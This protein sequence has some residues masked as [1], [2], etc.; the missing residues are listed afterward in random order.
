M[1]LLATFQSLVLHDLNV[2]PVHHCSC[3]SMQYVVNQLPLSSC[4]NVLYS[5]LLFS[6]LSPLTSPSFLLFAFFPFVHYSPLLLCH[7]RRY[8][9]LQLFTF[10]RSFSRSFSAFPPSFP[11]LQPLS[12]PQAQALSC[13]E[14]LCCY[15]HG[16]SG[17]SR[18][19]SLLEQITGQCQA[20]ANHCHTSSHSNRWGG[21]QQQETM[22]MNPD[23]PSPPLGFKNVACSPDCIS[24]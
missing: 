7:F 19:A 23:E 10:T 4:Q 20:S 13:V 3:D 21:R 2:F 15:Q 24:P 18:L 17:C 22:I 14:S 11:F 1:Y 8:V 6:P 9:S 5:F 16:Q 12:A